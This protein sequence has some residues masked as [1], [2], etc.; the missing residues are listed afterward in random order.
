MQGM[1]G[2]VGN[3]KAARVKDVG[4]DANGGFDGTTNAIYHW[5]KPVA[6]L[7]L[8][9]HDVEKMRHSTHQMLRRNIVLAIWLDCYRL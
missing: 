5:P 9:D 2:G 1:Q 8:A 4:V 3:P 6:P 7:R